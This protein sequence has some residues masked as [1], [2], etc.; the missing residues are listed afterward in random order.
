MSDERPPGLRLHS[1]TMPVQRAQS[2]IHMRLLELQVEHDLTDVEMLQIVMF[3][4]GRI[5]VWMLREERYPGD[6]DHK[7]DEE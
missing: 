6:P 7:A 3:H 4:A 2:A 5:A 1:R